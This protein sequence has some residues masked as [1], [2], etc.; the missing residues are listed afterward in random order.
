MDFRLTPE[1][2][3]FADSVRRF[4]EKH[5]APGALERAHKPD[6]PWDVSRLTISGLISASAIGRPCTVARREKA[7]T[8]RASAATSPFGRL[9]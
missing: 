7:D 3:Q 2:E 9:R 1:Q 6:Y 8:T 4:A 5:L